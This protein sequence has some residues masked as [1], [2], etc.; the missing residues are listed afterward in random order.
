MHP[1][2]GAQ[3]KGVWHFMD[4]FSNDFRLVPRRIQYIE[5][6]ALIL[7][8]LIDTGIPTRISPIF[9]RVQVT[10]I[11]NFQ[12][13]TSGNFS[14]DNH[15]IRA[16]LRRVIKR[17]NFCVLRVSL[18]IDYIGIPKNLRRKECNLLYCMFLVLKIKG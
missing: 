15:I 5:V 16:V 14:L 6:N 1:P 9:K 8:S 3:I 12:R 7:Q 11:S 13:F 10:E 17:P 2:T 18:G 4:E